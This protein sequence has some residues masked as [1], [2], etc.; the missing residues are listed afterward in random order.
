MSTRIRS[1]R[2]AVR[3]GV[4]DEQSENKSYF[5]WGVIGVVVSVALLLGAAAVYTLPIGERTYTANF[6]NSGG[7]KSGDEVRIAGIGVGSVRSVALSG[8]HVE[9]K[10]GV[11][12]DVFVG[13][14]SSLSIQLLTPIGGHFVALDSTG[15]DSLGDDAVPPERTQTPFDLSDTLE[16]AT[17][18]VR[19]ID[20]DTLRST[21]A[22][23]DKALTVEPQATRDVVDNLTQ[24]TDVIAQ[25]SDDLE[26][27]LAVSDEY[28]AALSSDDLMLDELVRQ[29]GTLTKGFGDKRT[30]VVNAFDLLKRLFE[31]FHRPLMAYEEGVEPAVVQ[32]EEIVQKVFAQ[33]GD[34][35]GAITQMKTT[36]DQLSGLL[37]GG[38]GPVVDQSNSVVTGAAVCIPLPGKDC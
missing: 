35:D 10:F 15:S 25:R 19:D 11:D 1:S 24:L 8:D 26:R 17:P 16:K 7:I 28:T 32:L 36:S 9:V 37:A 5:L 27:G 4:R 23:V 31:L 30:D 22:E 14:T 33:F 38:N 13:N 12:R 29:L 20:G 34:F 18:L 6:R 2:K 3:K 21:I